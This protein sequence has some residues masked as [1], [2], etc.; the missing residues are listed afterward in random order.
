[1]GKI[2]FITGNDGHY[3]FDLL[4]GNDQVILKS[5]GFN[6]ETDREKIIDSMRMSYQGSCWFERKRSQSGEY[7]FVLRSDTGSIIGFSPMYASEAGRDN[8]IESVRN[9][10]I[11]ASVVITH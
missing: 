10:V 1:M 4:A 11:D 7:Y 5:W 3:Y 6:N 2:V 9:N 8:G